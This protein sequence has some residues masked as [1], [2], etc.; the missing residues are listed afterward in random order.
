M[1]GVSC[2]RRYLPID[3]VG[4]Y[5]PGGSAPLFSTLLMLA[6]PATIAGC[7]DIILCTPCD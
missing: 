4:L 5:I 7:K 3:R 2:R 1:A 6:I